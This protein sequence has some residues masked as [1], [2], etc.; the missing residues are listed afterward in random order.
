[1]TWYCFEYTICYIKNQNLEG[2]PLLWPT[3]GAAWC[4][5][6]PG[7][8]QRKDHKKLLKVKQFVLSDALIRPIDWLLAEF[9]DTVSAVLLGCFPIIKWLVTFLTLLICH[10]PVS[11]AGPKIITDHREVVDEINILWLGKHIHFIWKWQALF[12]LQG[13]DEYCGL[14]WASLL[15]I[16]QSH[17]SKQG[18]ELAWQRTGSCFFAW[19][20]IFLSQKNRNTFHK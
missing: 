2:S 12:L 16:P 15:S 13:Q 4:A 18:L 17:P 11:L 6:I 5:P 20:S 14:K 10:S 9:A 8:T 3:S 19:Y 7:T 1:M